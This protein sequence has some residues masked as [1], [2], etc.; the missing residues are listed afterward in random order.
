VSTVRSL[1]R[2]MRLVGWQRYCP[3][4]TAHARRFLSFGN[5]SRPDAL[6]PWCRSLERHRLVW[7]YFRRMTDLLDGR[8]KRMLHVAPEPALERVLAPGVGPGYVTAD[9]TSPAAA[10]KMDLTDIR[11]PD[12]SFDV[13]YCSHVLEHVPDDRSAMRELH[14]VLSPRGWALLLV[15]ITA[16]RTVEDPSVT[17]PEE[18]LRLFG[19]KD[20]VRRYGPD[21]VD[22][23]RSVGLAVRKV[24][25]P[26]FLSAPEIRRMGITAAGEIFQCRK[27]G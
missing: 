23:L 16:D 26:D 6:C 9:L 8:L 25:A 5:P 20:H 15:P 13:I 12:G 10:E 19:Q 1:I 7:C 24:V 3:I 4:C 11:H 18:R 21:F 22:R 14:R 2:R 17:D 27:A